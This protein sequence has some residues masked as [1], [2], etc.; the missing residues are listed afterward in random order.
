MISLSIGTRHLQH[1]MRRHSHGHRSRSFVLARLG[2]LLHDML[3]EC[4]HHMYQAARAG[5]DAL[6]LKQIQLGL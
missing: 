6:V 5:K 2:K 1:V 3:N 4:M